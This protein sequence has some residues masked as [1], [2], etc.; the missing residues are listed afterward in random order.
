MQTKSLVER[1]DLEVVY[2]D[3]DSIMIN[4]RQLNYDQV[5]ELGKEVSAGGRQSE[6]RSGRGALTDGVDCGEGRAE[7]LEGR[8][9]R[10][11]S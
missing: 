3:T 6:E 5:M 2:G 8:G 4:S 1:M 7:G 11:G 9:G 10:K